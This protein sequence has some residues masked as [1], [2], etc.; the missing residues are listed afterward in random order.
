MN[1]PIVIRKM[2]VE[3]TKMIEISQS[4]VTRQ[5]RSLFDPNLPNSHKCFGVLDG[6]VLGI[7]LTDN[8]SNSTWGL[9]REAGL[10]ATYVGGD[11]DPL[12][13][14][15]TVNELRKVG[16][17]SFSFWPEDIGNILLPPN[18]DTVTPDRAL[19]FS[20]RSAHVTDLNALMNRIPEGSDMRP[21]DSQILE[22]C[23]WG[24]S[25]IQ[26]HGSAEA[27]LR[28]GIGF[29]LMNG[30]EILCEAYATYFSTGVFEMATVTHEDH[31]GRGYSTI[32]CAHAVQACEELGSVTLWF[33]GKTNLASA[34]V[35][36]KLGYTQTKE[37]G[38]ALYRATRTSGDTHG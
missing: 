12:V 14:S 20:N 37:F 9:V 19:K 5:L 13:L 35:A 34:A 6:D 23:L 21:M 8:P 25:Y 27:F 3:H 15:Q 22:R 16:D 2:P 31:Q 1:Q 26:A 11:I 30:D 28:K 18:P 4:E 38:G 33:C 17:V 36:R 7:I 32:T 24:E 10:G 29:C